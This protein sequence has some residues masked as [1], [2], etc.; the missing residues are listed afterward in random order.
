MS[1]DESAPKSEEILRLRWSEVER[2]LRAEAYLAAIIMMGSL[3]EGVLFFLFRE[4]SKAARQC[5][6][7]PKRD[8]KV[9]DFA[10]WKLG[11]MI[12]AARE[13]E[14]IGHG[15]TTLSQ[16]VRDFR[17]SVHPAKQ[18][19]NSENP[20][21]FIAE[22]SWQIVQRAIR[23][24]IGK[25]GSIAKGCEF[26]VIAKLANEAAV[27]PI[28]SSDIVASSQDKTK[29][30]LTDIYPAMPPKR[31][32]PPFHSM[33]YIHITEEC[34][35]FY[36]AP[37]LVYMVEW[38]HRYITFLPISRRKGHMKTLC[39]REFNSDIG[40]CPWLERDGGEKV[41]CMTVCEEASLPDGMSVVFVR[42]VP[43][44]DY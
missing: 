36:D 37:R 11:E 15:I 1:L 25:V 44:K 20:E 10:E 7:A 8:S 32:Q 17:N 27:V 24:E 26:Q 39:D 13:M 40:W 22:I 43:K 21:R 41:E 5:S 31:Y 2:C 30:I 42:F 38:A 33:M 6:C 34:R 28:V 3:L 14:W 18:L 23:D 35:E 16:S 19:K 29:T 9:K 4:N 12:D